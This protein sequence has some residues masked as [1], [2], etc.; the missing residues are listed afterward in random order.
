MTSILIKT[1]SLSNWQCKLLVFDVILRLCNKIGTLSSF[2]LGLRVKCYFPVFLTLGMTRC[3]RCHLLY[4]HQTP[5]SLNME[6]FFPYMFSTWNLWVKFIFIF[7]D[8]YISMDRNCKNA[9]DESSCYYLKLGDYYMYPYNCYI[10]LVKFYVYCTLYKLFAYLFLSRTS[11]LTSN[12][13][14]DFLSL[15]KLRFWHFLM[16]EIFLVFVGYIVYKW[17]FL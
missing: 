10:P 4:H 2:Y 1:I 14:I 6:Y 17:F 3:C 8:L 7:L 9:F 5:I 16:S 11:K 15:K 13:Q 12:R